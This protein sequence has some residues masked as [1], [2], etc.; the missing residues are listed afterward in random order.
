MRAVSVH[1]LLER[2][3]PPSP[4]GGAVSRPSVRAAAEDIRD[5]FARAYG[6]EVIPLEAALTG[7]E[8]GEEV[9]QLREMVGRAEQ[10]AERI[11]NEK[12]G[13]RSAPDLQKDIP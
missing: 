6:R 3:S 8:D 12:G 9:E 2:Q 1:D 10:E 11:N 5:R 7:K 4:A 13:W